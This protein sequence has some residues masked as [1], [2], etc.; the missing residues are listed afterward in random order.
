[1][2]AIR[3]GSCTASPIAGSGG[4]MSA[5]L[6]SRV[7]SAS[8]SRRALAIDMRRIA[9]LLRDPPVTA[10]GGEASVNTS[11]CSSPHSAWEPGDR[12][13]APIGANNAAAR[14][15]MATQFGVLADKVN[16]V[17]AQLRGQCDTDRRRLQ[18]LERKV[19][20]QLD[21]RTGSNEG[22]EK[23]AETQGKV[24]GLE[25]ETQAL[26]RRI[27]KCIESLD[28]RIWDR[29]SG[30]EGKC[31]SLEQQMQALEQQSRHTSTTTEE[32][33]KRQAAKIRRSEHAV[34]EVTRR[35]VKAEDEA[36][37]QTQ[38]YNQGYTEQ[39][40]SVLEQNQE[41][42]SMD[43]Q[44]LQE[45][46]DDG[47][48]AYGDNQGVDD[49]AG[50]EASQ[51]IAALE[52]MVQMA[53]R[54][55]ANVEKKVCTQIEDLA[56]SMAS[57]RVKADGQFHRVAS[58]TE[59]LETAH[60]PAMES[61]RADF[62]QARAQDRR[63]A[64]GE[65]ASMRARVQEVMDGGEEANAEVREA[66]RQARAEI[67][68]I[69]LRPEDNPMLRNME[70]R[71]VGQEREVMDLRARL[72]T[73]PQSEAAM[74]AMEREDMEVMEEEARADGLNGM[75]LEDTRRRLEWLEEQ[76][77]AGAA[78]SA[79]EKPDN[80][81]LSQLQNTVV[82]LVEQ[83]SNMKQRTASGEGANTTLQ[84]QVQQL[85]NHIERRFSDDSGSTR[86][87]SEV[88]AKI[89]AVTNQVADIAARLLEVESDH[90]FARENDT[91]PGLEV[92]A[93]SHASE[94]ASN[95]PARGLPPLPR[96]E[97]ERER[98]VGESGSRSPAL[99][100]QL[101]ATQQQLEAV[102]I[103][104]ETMDEL[105]ERVAELE[106]RCNVGSMVGGEVVAPEDQVSFGAPTQVS[107]AT[108]DKLGKEVENL[109]Q[110][111]TEMRGR[112]MAAERKMET[113]PSPSKIGDKTPT[114]FADELRVVEDRVKKIESSSGSQRDS[115]ATTDQL[116]TLE[117]RVV[118]LEDVE[119][120]DMEAVEGR[121][122]KLESSSGSPSVSSAPT[123]E[124]KVFEE[125]MVKLEAV[126][127]S[128]SDELFG[129]LRERVEGMQGRLE[130]GGALAVQV[131]ELS[132]KV[133]KC[134]DQSVQIK[135][136]FEDCKEK[137]KE[138]NAVLEHN[139]KASTG[140]L[141]VRIVSL[142][143]AI[144]LLEKEPARP[145]EDAAA[146]ARQQ[147]QAQELADVK[148]QSQGLLERLD[149]VTEKTADAKTATDALSERLR[150]VEPLSKDVD[151][152]REEVA[153]LAGKV[154]VA[155]VGLNDLRDTRPSPASP[156]ASSTA[157]TAAD[158]RARAQVQTQ[159]EDLRRQV[160]EE[161]GGLSEHQAELTGT[162]EALKALSEKVDKA[163]KNGDDSQVRQQDVEARR[164]LEDLEK[165]ADTLRQDVKQVQ[166]SADMLRQDVKQLHGSDKSKELAEVRNQIADLRTKVQEQPL[167]AT[168]AR[169][170][171]IG[172]SSPTEDVT[173]SP[174]AFVR[175]KLDLLSE[176]VA[177]LQCKVS[178]GVSSS[179]QARAGDQSKDAS[180]LCD[181]SLT[182]DQ[183]GGVGAGGSLNFSMTGVS[184][185]PAGGSRGNSRGT[186]PEN[187][188]RLSSGGSEP[189]SPKGGRRENQPSVGIGARAAKKEKPE[190][191]IGDDE[192]DDL[193]NDIVGGSDKK[194][195]DK[196][197][198]RPR[199]PA[200][201]F[202]DASATG[203]HL[204]SVAEE[205]S[206][207]LQGDDA[208]KHQTPKSTSGAGSGSA[209][210]GGRSRTTPTRSSPGSHSPAGL[211]ASMTG[212]E[213]SIGCDISVED[214]LQ[215]EDECDHVENVKPN[216]KAMQRKSPDAAAS[217][218]K[219]I[220]VTGSAVAMDA[221]DA[222][223]SPSASKSPASASASK[224]PSQRH[225]SASKS[226]ASA[227]AS[228]SKS[229]KSAKASPVATGGTAPAS[230]LTAPA[231]S[232]SKSPKS[233]SGSKSPAG[234][235]VGVAGKAATRL[236]P[237][238]PGDKSGSKEEEDKYDESFD[239]DMSV[240]ES[241]EESLEGSGSGGWGGGEAV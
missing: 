182:A 80:R 77:T 76:S 57:L 83:V 119:D 237:L 105:N 161:L 107:A 192:L 151:C 109:S 201:D 189:S 156:S 97:V 240:P 26:S 64:D 108:S 56:A 68:A 225:G 31:R 135:D 133:S 115:T 49:D 3:G 84:Q 205:E 233:L 98:G 150:K 162:K 202:E 47:L 199:P 8:P 145:T 38:G 224:S 203:G 157:P 58:L 74:D 118:K 63:E 23:W 55:L 44:Q 94:V 79:Y 200:L 193:M 186:S 85:Q 168:P 175:N 177:D 198:N 126:S 19:E 169:K 32:V 67:A 40:F 46:L 171:G 207:D 130:E 208:T 106:N 12:G 121:L 24:N 223:L 110:E 53:E 10:G 204:P 226:P 123:A 20:S 5:H 129:K 211:D 241:I 165:S 214:S 176:Q 132:Q 87:V 154:S 152:L 34:E 75:E 178:S 4:G 114:W 134:E 78:T 194:A 42:L 101:E 72:E 30:S 125:R 104:L 86:A 142:E 1:M 124:L 17:I 195:S 116:K 18:Q 66:L 131:G 210:I 13:A 33:L 36:R 141:D 143:S 28:K 102:A 112:L 139:S 158:E 41:Q 103:H 155:E 183:T 220:G 70:E 188:P 222:L 62:T 215:L 25:E 180:A 160:L 164:R 187:S 92:S 73:L 185:R 206:T 232:S 170:I 218:G 59:R 37:T 61:M 167:Q 91:M 184:E 95:A 128:Q 51:G 149:S 238:S 120:Q 216:P 221:I 22:R 212:N 127:A 174:I 227:S 144:K 96:G 236:S 93:V 146:T 173:S 6:A 71:L 89:G 39:R 21:D 229:P 14:N 179:G 122:L 16:V 163:S 138:N 100:Q 82:E 88:E 217:S 159:V 9:S 2:P 234:M 137:H 27:D 7:R 166:N 239:D 81:Q 190:D 60:E 136:A 235:G 15:A 147:K 172:G 45:Q 153:G 90:E 35:L 48:Q 99:Q 11:I 29:T 140:K 219:T 228:S 113:P 197:D 43:M 54:N 111:V 231:A 181:F 196:G 213:V 65:S 117:K 191:V 52:E 50:G 230:S 69:S 148:T 209:G